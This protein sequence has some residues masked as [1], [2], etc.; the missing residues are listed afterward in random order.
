MELQLPIIKLEKH[1]RLI[2]TAVRKRN[3]EGERFFFR[4]IWLE[5]HKVLPKGFR[6]EQMDKR[7]ISDNGEKIHVMGV[8]ALDKKRTV[9]PRIDKMMTAIWEIV[10]SSPTNDFVPFSVI[11]KKIRVSEKEAAFLFFLMEE[12]DLYHSGSKNVEQTLRYEAIS[13]KDNLQLYYKYNEYPGIT[14]LLSD[15]YAAQAQMEQEW[16]T[17]QEVHKMELQLGKTQTSIL[18][19]IDKKLGQL[20][21][22][23]V[24]GLEEL[25]AEMD[26]LK[27]LL[28]T[29]SKKHWY[30]TFFGKI[31]MK[32]LDK[33]LLEPMF[34]KILE[35]GK[36]FVKGLIDHIR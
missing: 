18:A 25:A 32:G 6:L 4:D 17:H 2:L 29:Q 14:K 19:Y 22:A 16:F 15:K 28:K 36:P 8:I 10:R 9:V 35:I 23:Q 21:V 30:E 20:D 26:E 11:A 1:E 7:L 34:Q 5:L 31:W 13:V 27:G 24:K 12:A 33:I 3:M